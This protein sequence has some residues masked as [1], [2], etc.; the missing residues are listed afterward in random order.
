MIATSNRVLS[1]AGAIALAVVGAGCLPGDKPISI[2]KP[3]N[4]NQTTDVS[5]EVSIKTQ[6]NQQSL[7]LSINGKS[8]AATSLTIT[9]ETNGAKVTG[10]FVAADLKANTYN[11]FKA[12]ATDSNGQAI[13][14]EVNFVYAPAGNTPPPGGSNPPPGGSNAPPGGSN[15][16]P[17][18][19]NPPAPPVDATAPTLQLTT[20][21]RGQFVGI[22]AKL[23]ITGTAKDETKMG[24]LTVRLDNKA[25]TNQT[26]YLHPTTGAYSVEVTFAD[27]GLHRIEIVAKDAAGNETS[28][29]VSIYA[30][31][32]A[33]P[34]S[35]V[36]RGV[37]ASVSNHGLY[38]I[39]ELVQP[40]LNPP[41]F[42]LNSFIFAPPAPSAPAAAPSGNQGCPFH[43]TPSG[44]NPPAPS[45]PA[46]LNPLWKGSAGPLSAELHL[47]YANYTGADITLGTT[48]GGIQTRARIDNFKLSV[49]ARVK[50]LFSFKVN[51]DV[52][53]NR[54]DFDGKMLVSK[55]PWGKIKVGLPTANVNL[56]GFLF[57][58]HGIP[59][60]I[61]RLASGLL[62]GFI[63]K[64]ASGMIKD[65]AP[66]KIEELLNAFTVLCRNVDILGKTFHV[67]G[68]LNS[69]AFV[70]AGGTLDLNAMVAATKND[71]PNAVAL[72][73]FLSTP[74]NDVPTLGYAQDV[75][76]AVSD[77]ALN[78]VLFAAYKAGSTNLTF[79]QTIKIDGVVKTLTVALLNAFLGSNFSSQA[80]L[81]NGL[82]ISID[83][84]PLLAPVVVL[85]QSGL[86][87]FQA[88]DVFIEVFVGQPASR[89]KLFTFDVDVNIPVDSFTLDTN[90]GT[91]A[92]RIDVD[93]A[94]I[95]FEVTD[96][97]LIQLLVA[98]FKTFVPALAK[99]AVPYLVD[100]ISKRPVVDF[101]KSP[102]QLSS[103][104]L[105]A[106]KGYLIGKVN[107]R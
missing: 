63:E 59:D 44:T 89:Q 38:T 31:T 34:T 77:D 82:P 86:A 45:T 22:G 65:I 54:I 28:K 87:T 20:P 68:E 29:A 49:Q 56:T 70:S 23:A 4:G 17:G 83:V 27:A 7:A 60:F 39:G 85:G 19:N 2:V 66:P 103:V 88:H 93:K 46:P 18:G 80:N 71:N 37:I 69:A 52:K 5:F 96:Q 91:I 16:P 53:A 101:S 30:G 24:A 106:S 33:S 67:G 102:V 21:I 43:G 84:K 25:P 61:E 40:F 9:P 62:T 13:S 90:K 15:P 98:Q 32:A 94:L 42:V 97:P 74:S 26:Q 47:T 79:N 48:T 73:G 104:S 99:V 75:A 100:M 11:T 58:I 8:I 72:A 81:Q 12:S 64:K 76:L 41:K 1:L 14:D 51:G 92:P 78:Q 10:S 50:A 57:D 95:E 35:K 107:L 105:S 55:S 6:I 3:A 36:N